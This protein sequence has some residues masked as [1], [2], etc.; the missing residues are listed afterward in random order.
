[1]LPIRDGGKKN[2][3]AGWSPGRRNKVREERHNGID[4][5]KVQDAEGGRYINFKR[6]F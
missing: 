6:R 3:D 2:G 4:I 1:M 5:K